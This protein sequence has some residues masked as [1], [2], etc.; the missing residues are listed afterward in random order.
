LDQISFLIYSNLFEIKDFFVVV[1]NKSFSNSKNSKNKKYISE[2][3]SMGILLSA[4]N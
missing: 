3:F 1:E 2:N 4:I